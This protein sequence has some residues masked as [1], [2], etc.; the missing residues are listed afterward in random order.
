MPYI[1]MAVP[2]DISTSE[3]LVTAHTLPAEERPMYYT[4]Q[5]VF[6]QYDFDE[7]KTS[8][9]VFL[10]DGPWEGVLLGAGPWEEVF[11][12]A[13]PWNEVFLAV[14]PLYLEKAATLMGTSII[15]I[16]GERP[17]RPQLKYTVQGH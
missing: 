8:G 12:G 5:K 4:L 10:G 16:H 9:E 15:K 2:L 7:M 14:D 6:G 11:L 17:L 13:D 1:E 3:P